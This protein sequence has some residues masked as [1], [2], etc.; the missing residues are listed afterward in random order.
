MDSR[1]LVERGTILRATVGSTVHGLH[2]TILLILFVPDEVALA[3]TESAR[4][5]TRHGSA[6]RGSSSLRPAACRCRCPSR[7]GRA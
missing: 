7:S 2:P 1:E 6:S 4:S 5:C 3:K